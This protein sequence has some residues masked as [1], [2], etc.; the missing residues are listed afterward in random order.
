MLIQLIFLLCMINVSNGKSIEPKLNRMANL[1]SVLG[2][3]D[4][5]SNQYSIGIFNID[6]NLQK[7]SIQPLDDDLNDYIIVCFDIIF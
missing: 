7:Q 3:R 4:D 1:L 5:T 6:Q 2:L